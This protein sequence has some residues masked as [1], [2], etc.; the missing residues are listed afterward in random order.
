LS[1]SGFVWVRPPS[2]LAKDFEAYGHRVEAALYAAANAWGQ[3]IQDAART[4]AS[5]AD[6][7]ANARSGLFY[8]V[9]GFGMGEMIG[10]VSAGAKALMSE[11][12]VESAG[13]DEI[14]IVLAH[15]VYY[16][17]HLELSHGGKNAIIMSTIEE[18]LPAL[19]ALIRKS[20]GSA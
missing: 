4:N 8:A 1:N 3:S 11:T 9:E 17:K 12:S 2:E 18:H 20:Y 15:T 6:R 5:W 14:I 7:T 10:E 13:A 19:E 16:G